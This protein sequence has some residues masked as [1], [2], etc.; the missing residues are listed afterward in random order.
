MGYQR[1]ERI[2]EVWKTIEGFSNYEV[3]NQGSIRRKARKTWHG[4]SK[5]DIFLKEKIM[6]QR[7]NKSCKCYFL[8]LLNDEN[9]RK[10]VYPHKEVA[11]AFCINI[12]PE[13]YTMIVHLD[14]NPKNNDS[15][16]LEWVSPSEHMSFQFEVGNKNNFEVWK[17]RKKRY[18]NGFKSQPKANLKVAEDTRKT[19]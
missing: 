15:T 10:T 12:L 18:K 11:K 7:W 14:N 6:R 13:E 17:T 3:S 1:I 5:K 16:N 2:S 8:D 9:Q 4:G 19:A